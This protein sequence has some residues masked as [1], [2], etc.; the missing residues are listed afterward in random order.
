MDKGVKSAAKDS[1]VLTPLAQQ[2]D[3]DFLC[4]QKGAAWLLHSKPLP[5]LLKWIEYDAESKSVTLVFRQGQVMQLGLAIPNA[6]EEDLANAEEA[7]VMFVKGD[8]EIGDF[9]FVPVIV[10]QR[11]AMN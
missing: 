7:T 6:M 8:G 9:I 10:Q 3:V 5:A 4:N 2:M 11:T 1:A